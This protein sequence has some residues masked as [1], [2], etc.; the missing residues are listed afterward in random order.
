MPEA[1]RKEG[2]G[3]QEEEA[4][5]PGW[6]PDPGEGDPPYSEGGCTIWVTKSCGGGGVGKPGTCDGP[7]D[8]PPGRPPEDEPV[9]TL[10]E[11]EVKGCKFTIT[12]VCQ[13]GW[14]QAMLLEELLG[15]TG[16]RLADVVG[17]GRRLS[18]APGGAAATGGTCMDRGGH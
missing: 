9:C 7:P 4:V 12:R 5:Q 2:A 10:D 8:W 3:A 11:L 13:G 18:G 17:E 15:G 14:Q 6:N 16:L 1:E